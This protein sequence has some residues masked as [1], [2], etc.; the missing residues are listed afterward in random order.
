MLTK[1][2]WTTGL[3]LGLAGSQPQ[4]FEKATAWQVQEPQNILQT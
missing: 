1:H 3:V 4:G 2:S